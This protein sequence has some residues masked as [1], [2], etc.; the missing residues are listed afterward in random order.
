[1][2]SPPA[3]N[4]A[5]TACD[6]SAAL[7]KS[8]DDLA[9]IVTA[10]IEIDPISTSRYAARKKTL[11]K[12]LLAQAEAVAYLAKP[13]PDTLLYRGYNL[14]K[15]QLQDDGSLLIEPRASDLLESWTT[16][17]SWAFEHADQFKNGIVIRK[18]ASDLEV[19]LDI[20]ALDNV[21]GETLGVECE[22]FVRSSRL[23]VP[24][25]GWCYSE[26]QFADCRNQP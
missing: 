5:D 22:V 4:E 10:W 12:R 1:L 21:I 18:P 25:A 6:E 2:R 15:G 14:E 7:P 23:F 11:A 24:S 3:H 19:F 20:A 17:A 9:S 13:A 16:D 26:D 8:L